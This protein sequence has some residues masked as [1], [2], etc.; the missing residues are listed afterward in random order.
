MRVVVSVIVIS[1][2]RIIVVLGLAQSLLLHNLLEHLNLHI[3]L[4]DL[5]LV[6]L[7]VFVVRLH[8]N[9]IYVHLVLDLDLF[10][11]YDL[12]A[13]SFLI[14]REMCGFK[15]SPLLFD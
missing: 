7:F 10:L 6:V 3:V 5:D 12:D 14:T 11:E 9:R 1:E 2:D 13:R 4:L 15:N 8:N